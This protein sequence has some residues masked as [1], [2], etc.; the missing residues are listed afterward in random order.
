MERVHVAEKVSIRTAE[1][2]N[3]GRENFEKEGVERTCVQSRCIERAD[4]G[5]RYD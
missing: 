1:E 4:V 2:A 5:L 3:V